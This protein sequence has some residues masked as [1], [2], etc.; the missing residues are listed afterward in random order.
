M[1]L[2]TAPFQEI[3][4]HPHVL[5]SL[6]SPSFHLMGS[7]S[8]WKTLLPE[9]TPPYSTNSTSPSETLS[10][11]ITNSTSSSL[12]QKASSYSIELRWCFMVQAARLSLKDQV[13]TWK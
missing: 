4:L 1:I 9:L 7:T 12:A 3:H 11:T 13:L 8:I 5:S 2:T 10:V 6:L